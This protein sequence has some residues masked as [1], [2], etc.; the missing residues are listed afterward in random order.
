[1]ADT[2]STTADE[3]VVETPEVT[4]ATAENKDPEAALEETDEGFGDESS[5]EGQSEDEPTSEDEDQGEPEESEEEAKP[6]SEEPKEDNLSEAEQRKAHNKEMAEQR[7]RD[8]QQREASLKEDQAAYLEKAEDD[9][10]LALRQLQVDAYNNR[11][12]NVSNKLTNGYERAL[13]DFD[14]LSSTDPDVQAEVN[15]AIDAF[16]AMYVTVDQHGNPTEVRADFYAFLQSKA[17]SI[18]KLTGIGARQ[19]VMSKGKEKSKTLTVP[20]RAPKEPKSDPDVD[21]FDEEANKW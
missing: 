3:P 17:D 4:E 18:R 7:I 20:S 13:K 12:D 1:M 9:K 5:D 11:V 2:Q 6:E 10:D 21:A 14:I 19:Q 15:Q 16:Q 8:K